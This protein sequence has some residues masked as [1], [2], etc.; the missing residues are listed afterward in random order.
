MF[1]VREEAAG[2]GQPDSVAK[3]TIKTES[4]MDIVT[5][6]DR[7]KLAGMSGRIGKEVMQCS[8]GFGGN[9]KLVVELEN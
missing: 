3:I 4:F 5:G 6:V 2:I 7:S 1:N 9:G 8:L